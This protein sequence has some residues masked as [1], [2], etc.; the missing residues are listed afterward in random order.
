ML[1]KVLNFWQKCIITGN[2]MM[3]MKLMKVKVIWD[4][5]NISETWHQ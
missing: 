4:E 3:I 1:E 5:K 2:K